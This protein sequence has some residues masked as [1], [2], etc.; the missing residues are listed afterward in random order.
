MLSQI[1]KYL[2]VYLFSMVK[3]IGGP[4]SGLAFGLSWI[5]TFIFTVLGMM[6]SVLLFSLLGKNLKKRIFG[7]Y[8]A[9]KKLFTSRNRK[10]VYIWRKYGLQGVAF[11]TPVIFSPIIGTMVAT[12]F[13]EPVKRI[14]FYMLGS[15]IFWGVIFSLLIQQISKLIFW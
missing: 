7:R 11:L 8:Y 6:T 15:A 5:E 3:F 10:I 1:G 14:F 13:G 12:S 2:T 4:A 9:K